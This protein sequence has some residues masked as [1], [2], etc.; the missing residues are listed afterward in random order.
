MSHRSR[1]LVRRPL[2]ATLAVAGTAFA[3]AVIAGPAQAATTSQYTLTLNPNANTGYAAINSNGDIIGNATGTD[4]FATA[5]LFRAGSTTPLLLNAPAGQAA[6][7]P[8][9][10][11]EALTNSDQVV[12][13]SDTGNFTALEWPDSATPTDLSQLPFLASSLFCTMAT[14]INNNGL[15]VGYGQNVKDADTPFTIQDSK[16]TK[17][18]VLPSGG[19]DAQPIAVN[20]TGTIV[21][22]ADTST[23]DFK[24]VEWVNSKISRLANLSGTLTSE[25]VDIN[26]SGEAVGSAVLADGNAHPVLWANGKATELHFGADANDSTANAINDS[27]VVVGDGGNGDAFVYQNGTATDLNT[28]IPAD[29]GVTLATADGINNNGDIVGTAVNAQ[30]E[31]FGYELTP[32]G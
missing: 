14:S 17:L 26:S 25:A 27:G 3:S 13:E 6:D 28:L 23:Q 16:V 10:T 11:A 1:R 20:N 19:F 30:G 15:I 4:G 9:V 8:L 22:Q 32:A 18:P 29:S 5:A 24:A 12:G 2:I 7:D 21:G 31:Q